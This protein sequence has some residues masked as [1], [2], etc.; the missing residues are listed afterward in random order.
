MHS[1]GSGLTLPHSPEH[2]SPSVPWAFSDCLDLEVS[3]FGVPQ[4]LHVHHPELTIQAG[5]VFGGSVLGGSGMLVQGQ[6]SYQQG[7]WSAREG[8]CKDK[9]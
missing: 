1:S 2:F 8:G 7:R 4:G 3:G 5:T 6:S 9:K